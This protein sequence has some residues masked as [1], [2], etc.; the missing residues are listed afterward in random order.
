MADIESILNGLSKEEQ[1]AVLQLLKEQQNG[2]YQSL[3]NI[4]SEDYTEMPVSVEEFITNP[5][6]AGNYLQNMYPYWKQQLIN[7]FDKGKH[8]SEVAYTGSIGVG[9]A[10]KMD[11]NLLGP[12]GYFKMR[13]AKVG[14]EVFGEDG[15]LHRITG[16]FPQGV[17]P[18]YR[19][20][21][22]DHSFV[23]CT[24]NHLWTIR[25][26]SYPKYVRKNKPKVDRWIT[27]DLSW[28]MDKPL[29][30]N[31]GKLDK[32]GH[33]RSQR[34]FAIPVT[35]PVKFES[36]EN[37]AIHPYLLGQIISDGN[38]THGNID[39]SI[40]EQDVK[41]KVEKILKEHYQCE[42]VSSSYTSSDSG[43]YRV[44]GIIRG[45]NVLRS[46]IQNLGITK[47][48]P[49]K[50][51]P[52]Q[53]LFSSV[54]NR[55]KLLQGLFDGDGSIMDK[56]YTYSTVS[57]KLYEDM[58]FLIESLGG[59]VYRK[60]G[61]PAWYIKNGERYYTGQKCW[62]FLFK[63]PDSIKP[64]S[65]KKH[66][67]RYDDGTKFDT[68]VL[69]RYIDKIEY[70]KD[71]EC[72]CIT[73]DN[74]SGLF[75]MDNFTV[76]HNS[77]IA[78]VGLAYELYKLMCLKNPQRYWGTNKTI[79]VAFFNNNLELAK[80]VGFSAMHDLIRKSEWFL[81]HGEFRGRVNQVYQPNKDI[82]LV[83]GSLPSHIIGKDVFC[84]TG[85][86]KILTNSSI[87]TAS[88]LSKL[89]GG[90]LLPQVDSNGDTHLSQPCEVSY[91][92][93][94]TRLVEITLENNDILEVTPEHRLMVSLGAYSEAQYI[95][96]NGKLYDPITKQFNLIKKV[97]IKELS[98]PLPV[99]DVINAYPYNNFIIVT[100]NGKHV[101]SHN[102]A[103]MDE[104]N[105]C[106]GEDVQ[107][108]TKLGCKK[109]KDI[110]SKDI[111][112]N[113]FEGNFI[114]VTSDGAKHTKTVNNFVEIIL[115]DNTILQ[116]SYNHKLMMVGGYYKEAKDICTNDYLA[117]P[118]N[119][120]NSM[121]VTNIRSVFEH[122]E[123]YDIINCGDYHNF[124]IVTDS[125]KYIVSHNSTG[126]SIHLEQNKIMS[127][128]NCVT[129]DT[130]VKT[131][132]G[133]FP[134]KHIVGS[135]IKSY[136]LNFKE[137]EYC[138]SN[139]CD[140][141]CTGETDELYE[142]EFE[143]GEILRCTGN[144]RLMLTDGSY[145]KVCD[146]TISDDI[147][148]TTNY[149][150]YIYETT[151]LINGKKYIGQMKIHSIKKIKLDKPEPIYDVVNCNP[152]NNYTIVLG[153]SEIIS[154]NSIAERISSRFTRDGVNWGSLYLVS[155]KKSEY[156]FLE[157]Y[158]RKQK[159]KPNFYV[160]DAKIWDVKPMGVYSGKKFNLAV[161][162]SNLPS[163]I[164][165]DD[166]DPIAYEKQ[167]YE[168]IQVPVEHKQ[169]FELDMQS[170]IMNV[171]GIS[172]SHVLK[173]MNIEQ[174]K[175][176]YTDDVNPFVEE[177]IPIGLNNDLLLQDFFNSALVPEEIY[178][179]PIFIHLDMAVKGDNAGIGA[180]A[181]M[182]FVN[183]SEYNVDLG[184][185]VETKKMAYRHVFSV[186]ICAPK[187]DEIHFAKVREF[188][189]Y[190][191]FNLG[192]NI[193]GVSADGFNC[194]TA[195]N[196]IITTFGNKRIVDLDA[197]K[198]LVLAYD[199]KKHKYKFVKFLPVRQSG[200]A[201]ELI[202][203]KL[204]GGGYIKCTPHHLIYTVDKTNILNGIYKQAKDITK[205]DVI[206]SRC[207]K[208]QVESI[209]TI[210]A[211][212]KIPVYDIEVPEY[213]NFVLSNG[214][215]VH[216]SVDMRQQL[217]TM[218]FGDVSLVSLDRTPQGYLA[219]KSAIA[220]KRISLL[221]LDHLELELV[222]LE[223]DNTTGKIDH[224]LNSSKDEAD[225]LAG[226]LYN[227]LLH[228]KDLAAD[229]SYLVESLV[230]INGIPNNSVS[231]TNIK[232]PDN[233]ITSNS[234]LSQKAM[235]YEAL[236]R[237]NL[238]TG[239]DYQE[240]NDDYFD[241]SDGILI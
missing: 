51:I 107:I 97:Q 69:Y 172:I 175:K 87:K 202:K 231:S 210:Y 125:G 113:Y 16:V 163:K 79:F 35:Q 85:N 116:C 144:H 64:F 15:E 9:K 165:P 103:L 28:I 71:A 32:K 59:Y 119:D 118:K 224:P 52:K 222:Q 70:I 188:L 186:G 44:S 112:Y 86:T 80:S 230:D 164:I 158:I 27:R 166:E 6:Y 109:I 239:G 30:L 46:L 92:K 95:K 190:L 168:V 199:I 196:E 178:S 174:I 94:T 155:S 102:C 187:N 75:L 89:R 42:L 194:L 47:T 136:S 145:K 53:Y 203:I 76:T 126:A 148:E 19:V 99:Y 3:T 209:I 26:G 137:N 60:E 34:R 232:I 10:V 111:I 1:K 139:K 192:W 221:H 212:E 185:V 73:V 195:D 149:Y 207:N 133:I 105:F 88:E 117:S 25:D 135:R 129:G 121:K 11:A 90:L 179:R 225:G 81:N 21:F 176:C 61:K 189:Y 218:G 235:E 177:I 226:A 204:Y 77:S 43:D 62:E 14:M 57:K 228:E 7:I 31:E 128:Y 132:D 29:R 205:D 38:T 160:A 54:E 127:T 142:V 130:L 66:E 143:N 233:K 157:S 18:I 93:D 152:Y 131:T 229:L 219:L 197:S 134:I 140:V 114:E 101:V 183:T 67:K 162:G 37:L 216:N 173:F 55:I 68:S 200:A 120:N 156:D 100:D 83:A 96:S 74:P 5:K 49:Y 220:E 171:A 182:G 50:F 2:N 208:G 159:D 12:D 13:D 82:Q 78:I 147:M 181:A 8:Y 56:K 214:A 201:T 215:V 63:L 241:P 191:K 234:D 170:A 167:G 22:A 198:D 124:I 33:S 240:E 122:K 237:V 17:M 106:L 146:L 39:L 169:S 24:A 238:Q 141:V 154:H 123:L 45:K 41:A 36:K 211:N 206:F 153:D 115:E 108:L 84:I 227:A 217:S 213:N 180:V 151:N 110:T 72:Q 223:R 23:E 150:G 184:K 104:V 138:I 161:G 4:L 65:S 193:K 58:T 236:K 40:Y 20:T 48:A 91:T 98:E